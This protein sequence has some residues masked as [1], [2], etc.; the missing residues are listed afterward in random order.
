MRKS[1]ERF[2]S[3]KKY[4]FL[5]TYLDSQLSFSSW[6]SRSLSSPLVIPSSLLWSSSRSSKTCSSEKYS[7]RLRLLPDAM[8]SHHMHNDESCEDVVYVTLKYICSNLQGDWVISSLRSTYEAIS[9]FLAKIPLRGWNLERLCDRWVRELCMYTCHTNHNVGCIEQRILTESNRLG[10]IILYSELAIVAYRKHKSLK[11]LLVTA[12]IPLHILQ[13]HF[14]VIK[15]K[16]TFPNL[17]PK[18]QESLA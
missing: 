13:Q 2:A 1:H 11:D 15:P 8:I 6:R 17:R 10:Q 9:W 16:W 18:F 12:K 3:A 14:G 5:E 4:Y 7:V